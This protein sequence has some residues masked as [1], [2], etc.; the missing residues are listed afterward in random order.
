MPQCLYLNK[1]ECA[2]LATALNATKLS[3]YPEHQRG[4][5]AKLT[6]RISG[7]LIDG[8]TSEDNPAPKKKLAPFARLR[9]EDK[10]W[11]QLNAELNESVAATLRGTSLK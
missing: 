11:Q 10:E 1:T 4:Y 3:S 6:R 7:F 9:A 2:V 5:L 8:Q